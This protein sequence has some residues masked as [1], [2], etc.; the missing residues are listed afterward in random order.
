MFKIGKQDTIKMN[1]C[2]TEKRII[3]KL[4]VII[5]F[6][7]MSSREKLLRQQFSKEVTDK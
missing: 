1:L 3:F 7:S 4:Y 5:F 6:L 2:I